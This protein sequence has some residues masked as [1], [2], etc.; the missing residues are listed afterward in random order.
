MSNPV[1]ETSLKCL[2]ISLEILKRWGVNDSQAILI[3][4][5]SSAELV[6]LPSCKVS[7]EQLV[8]TSYIL[9]IHAALRTLFNN[10]SNVYGFMTMKNHNPFF[11]GK[12]PLSFIA[13]GELAALE[14]VAEHLTALS[15]GN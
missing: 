10:P 6:Q 1:S 14:Q 8:R 13:S 15:I 5:I 12:T 7:S 4:N 11:D 9:N 3:L 2:K